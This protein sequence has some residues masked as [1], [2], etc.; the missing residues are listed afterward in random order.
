MNHLHA[1]RR[2][3]RTRG[4]RHSGWH[5]MWALLLLRK[6]L[7]LVHAM[8]I[9]RHMPTTWW[10]MTSR[11][12]SKC[13]CRHGSGMALRAARTYNPLHLRLLVTL[14]PPPLHRSS[15]AAVASASCAPVADCASVGSHVSDDTLCSHTPPRSVSSSHSC[16]VPAHI[17]APR[18]A[19]TVA[20]LQIPYPCFNGVVLYAVLFYPFGNI[21]TC[22]INSS[23]G[24]IPCAESLLSGY[25]SNNSNWLHGCVSVSARFA[26]AIA[27]KI[28][29][30]SKMLT[31]TICR[32]VW[33]E[34]SVPRRF[35]RIAT[36]TYDAMA[37][38]NCV[39]T[40]F[41]EVP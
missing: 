13:S 17:V 23:F 26:R 30:F 8:P 4:A 6:G 35:L 15:F 38:H 16:S 1:A 28:G 33:S 10:L 29:V 24:N 2:R 37:I 39:L 20:V 27:C 18:A 11:P 22:G 31:L 32:I 25:R 9:L 41:A 40:A 34:A 36:S 3:A 14:V 21:P 5:S 7:V 12:L 19:R